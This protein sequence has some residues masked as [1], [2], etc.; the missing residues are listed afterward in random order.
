MYAVMIAV[1]SALSL[2]PSEWTDLDERKQIVEEI[3]PDSFSGPES[4]LGSPRPDSPC[5]PTE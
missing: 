2:Q 3:A 5:P 1:L 4:P